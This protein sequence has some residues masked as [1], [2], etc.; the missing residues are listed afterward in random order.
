MTQ[1]HTSEINPADEIYWAGI[2]QQYA[3]SEDFINLENG[4]FS[5]QSKPVFDA[6][7]RY[8]LLLNQ[9]ASFF[10]RT[11]YPQRLAAVMQTLAD[12]TG[13]AVEELVLTRNLME[14]MNI[15][16]QGYPFQAG[17]EVVL[18]SLDYDAVLETFD[19]MRQRKALKLTHIRL[20]LN[21]QDDEEI[22]ACY[23]RAI[24]PKTRVILVTHM[25]HITGQIVP[26]AKIVQMARGYGVD[27]L[28]DAA[29]SFAQ[30][31][32]RL[33]ELDSDFVAVN[34][35]KW[36]GAPLGV[37]LLYIRKERIAEIA[38]LF[39]DTTCA[40]DDIR[41]F[42]HVGTTPPAPILAIEDAIAFHHSIGGKNK[43]ARLRYLKE[44]WVERVRG[45]L[46]I[47]LLTPEASHRSCAIAAFHVQGM[48][49]K[50]VVDYL[51]DEHRIFT[52]GREI[53]GKAGIRVTP[54]LY[55]S[56]AD[57]DRLIGALQCIA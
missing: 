30:I 41:K 21:P 14:A 16:I 33:P 31:D 5:V 25:I 11:K 24:T 48:E 53:E 43:E 28:V 47:E 1:T 35:H 29:H 2:R 37:G 4:Y 10:L 50:Q 57:L 40:A 38:P 26:V 12:F 15:L 23:E 18:S 27:V 39:G 6:F 56:T 44:Y 34:L 20:P 36:L 45:L 17:D 49:W 42:S 13:A 7:Q 51:F 19:M 46:R 9:E 32:Y 8:N 54:H 52:V 22:V 55:T 3:V